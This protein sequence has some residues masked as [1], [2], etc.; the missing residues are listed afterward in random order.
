[1]TH[2]RK[3]F[4]R[5]VD[6]WLHRYLKPIEKD[7]K[8]TFDYWLENS[9]YD[10]QRRMQLR[11]CYYKYR[12]RNRTRG[13]NKKFRKCK[14]FCKDEGYD[15]FKKPRLINSRIDEAKVFCGPIFQQIADRLFALDPFIKKIPFRDRP[16]VV[17]DALQMEGGVYALDDY[18]QY[19]SHFTSEVMKDTEFRLYHHM[20]KRLFEHR[21]FMDF[22]HGVLAGE[23]KC[24][25]DSF[26]VLLMATRMSGEMNTS[27]GNGFT[28]LM[29]HLY[30]V[31]VNSGRNN[32]VIDV[33]M[34]RI[35][36]EGDDS[37]A[38]YTDRNLIPTEQQM[39]DLGWTVKHEEVDKLGLASFCGCVFD[40][41]DMVII[42]DPV[43][44]IASFG[45]TPRRYIRAGT[46]VREEL[47]KA[48]AL[49]YLFQ[50]TN[51]PIIDPFCRQVLRQLGHVKIRDSVI[52]SF[53]PHK[54]EIIRQALTDAPSP[55]TTG[56]VP[57][58]TRL[59]MEEMY[60]ISPLIQIRLEARIL[61]IF[62]HFSLPLLKDF[63]PVSWCRTAST[64]VKS[65]IDDGFRCDVPIA[66]PDQTLDRLVLHTQVQPKTFEKFYKYK[67][68]RNLGPNK[69]NPIKPNAIK[70]DCLSGNI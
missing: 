3:E 55:W 46:K 58:K 63:A 36:V 56:N 33:M 62:S 42:A 1:M 39:R 49:S 65:Y 57:L 53:E 9:P 67:N 27:T 40:P 8:Y 64:F 51:S 43:R 2:N 70:A 54:Q 35:F 30:Q 50:Y 44:L 38:V 4:R 69:Q 59:L 23:N 12:N 10:T 68:F 28:N 34:G 11:E 47:M 45:W 60:K 21:E 26:V 37:I 17:K 5:F 24:C 25:F 32:D 41:E 6:L 15:A 22:C 20:T 31:W 66:S 29:V 18:S 52:R 48:K 7:E 61:S 14:S 13:R 16:K 19:E